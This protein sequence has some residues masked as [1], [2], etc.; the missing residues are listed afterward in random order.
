MKTE[1]QLKAEIAALQA[2]LEALH[3]IKPVE[4]TVLWS[5]SADF[6]REETTYD[7]ADFEAKAR[8]IAFRHRTGGYLKTKVRALLSNGNTVTVRCD[9]AEDDC[10]GFG[11]LVKEY[12]RFLAKNPDLLT[13]ENYPGAREFYECMNSITID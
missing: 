11:H 7:Y 8:S 10:H 5:E 12:Q 13:K 2:E 4:I 6:P 9:L 1:A 3:Q